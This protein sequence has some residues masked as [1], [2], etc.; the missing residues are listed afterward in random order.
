MKT[1][2]VCLSQVSVRSTTSNKN[3][4]LEVCSLLITHLNWICH[5][6]IIVKKL[7]VT[8]SH[9]DHKNNKNQITLDSKIYLKN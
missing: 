3:Q 8:D 5:V 4:W 1:D 2:G 7:K 6:F 9:T